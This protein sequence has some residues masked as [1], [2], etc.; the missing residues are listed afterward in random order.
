M[1]KI[2]QGLADMGNS[3]MSGFFP[4]LSYTVVH[5]GAARGIDD[6][7]CQLPADLRVRRPSR[8]QQSTAIRSPRVPQL[9]S[10]RS[11]GIKDANGDKPSFCATPLTACP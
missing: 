5:H 8:R 6:T 2:L 1:A 3:M 9:Q 4:S 7:P 11:R 10:R